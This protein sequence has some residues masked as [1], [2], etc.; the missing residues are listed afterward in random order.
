M[1]MF[2]AALF[3]I[4]KNWKQSRCSLIDEWIH[5][6]WYFHTTEYYSVIKRNELSSH[7]KI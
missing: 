1:Q 4:I 2:I 6:L 3:I 5:E 7:V